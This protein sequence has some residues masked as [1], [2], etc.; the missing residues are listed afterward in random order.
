MVL[1]VEDKE[2]QSRSVPADFGHDDYVDVND[3]GHAT[4]SSVVLIDEQVH[5]H[6]MHLYY[7]ALG[8]GECLPT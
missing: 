2:D 1:V 3:H 4:V 5:C 8:M 7:M 6:R